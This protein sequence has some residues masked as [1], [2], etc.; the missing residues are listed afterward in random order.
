MS[1]IRNWFFKKSRTK[2]EEMD[3]YWSGRTDVGRVRTHNEDAYVALGGQDCPPSVDGL[4]VVADGMGGHAAGEVASQMAVEAVVRFINIEISKSD[5]MTEQDFSKF[6]GQVMEQ[7]NREVWEAGQVHDKKGMGTTCT[8]AVVRGDKLFLSHV[9]DSRAYMLRD[10]QLHQI[11]TDHSWVE[12]AVQEGILTRD[13]ARTHPNRNV[14]TRA[15]G[16]EPKVTVD[17]YMVSVSAGDILLLCS[18]GLNSMVTDEEIQE[19]LLNTGPELA[20]EALVAAVNNYGG[21]D[22]TTAVVAS[23]GDKTG[24]LHS[25]GRSSSDRSLQDTVSVLPWWERIIKALRR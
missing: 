2:S 9:G 5:H 23:L 4:A 7:V 10:R 22:N 17:N 25:S 16:L 15:V 3:L 24:H 11:T 21:H 18:D 1:Q 12:E 20:P 13:Q 6:L 14:I 19:I 8:V